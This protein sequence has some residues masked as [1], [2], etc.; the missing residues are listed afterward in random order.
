MPEPSP[1]LPCPVCLGRMMDK[2]SFGPRPA[3]E[4]DR[5]PRCGGIWLD[6]GEIQA[7]RAR[8]RSSL[9]TEPGHRVPAISMGVCHGCQAP[10]DRGAEACGACG[11][12]NRLDCPRCDRPMQVQLVRGVRLDACSDCRGAWFDH[13]ELEAIWSESFDR[14]LAQRQLPGRR[15]ATAGAEVGAD[16]LFHSV[17]FAPDLVLPLA[18]AGAEAATSSAA[19]LSELPAAAQ[20]APELAAQTFEAVGEAAGSVF[21]AV[22]DLISGIF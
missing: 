6:H 15:A 21:E 22:V 11:S 20:A 10:L 7:L 8:A 1:R 12:T 14:A 16:L 5:C 19:L 2:V 18:G 17:I 13:H 4:V 3:L 9:P